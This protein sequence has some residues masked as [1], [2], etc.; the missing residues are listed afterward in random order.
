MTGP[1]TRNWLRRRAEELVL[2]F[3]LLTRLPL[4][5][6]AM[7][8]DVTLPDYMW[9]FPIVGFVVGHV[10]AFAYVLAREEG[11]LG[12]NLSALLAMAAA[13]LVTGALHEDGLAD[14]A[15]GIGGGRT[16]ERKLEIMR[17]SSIGSYGTVALFVV[18][19]VRW[20]ALASISDLHAAMGA[21]VL[22]HVL[23]R[24]F[25][26]IVPEYWRPARA[27]GLASTASKGNLISAAAAIGLSLA[28]VFLLGAGPAGFGA[29]VAAC[30]GV[31]GIAALA[32]RYLGGYTGDVFGAAEQIAEALVLIVAADLFSH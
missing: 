23:P 9:A 20:S 18:L 5:R 16:R 2:A 10:A 21:L 30:A 17:D 1:G 32:S 22:S 29:L 28:I 4:P 7:R 25:L 26:G 14:L 31:V 12:A 3:A 13:M 15:D 27:D 8:P 19:G 11:G 24:G 6:L